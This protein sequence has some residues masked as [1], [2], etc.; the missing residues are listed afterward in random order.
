MHS[1]AGFAGL[2]H[3]SGHELLVNVQ[4]VEEL[5]GLVAVIGGL[6]AKVVVS[7]GS[8]QLSARIVCK[9]ATGQCLVTCKQR[10]GLQQSQWLWHK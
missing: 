7:Q 10:G 4:K 5:H 9:Q 1:D 6:E 3:A 2:R 8:V